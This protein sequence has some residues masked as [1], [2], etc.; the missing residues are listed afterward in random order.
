MVALE[1]PL[2]HPVSSPDSDSGY[3]KPVLLVAALT[4][5]GDSS[6]LL[7]FKRPAE[8]SGA[9]S[10][11]TTESEHSSHLAHIIF[12]AR[13][14]PSLPAVGHH[15]HL[16]RSQCKHASSVAGA[17][18]YG[19]PSGY[20][21]LNLPTAHINRPFPDLV[22]RWIAAQFMYHLPCNRDLE[23]RSVSGFEA[24]CPIF[25]EVIV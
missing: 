11:L 14:T 18:L 12:S 19:A 7:W 20:I 21:Q 15:E 10:H 1:V 2:R 24:W 17:D 6:V 13:A 8:V 9:H 25:V 5:L 3:G 16:T 23:A 4:S 22:R